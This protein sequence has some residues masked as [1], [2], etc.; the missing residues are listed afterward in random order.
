MNIIKTPFDFLTNN[1]SLN[2]IA[3][4]SDFK[5]RGS[6]NYLSCFKYVDIFG[7]PIEL[8]FHGGRRYRSY[9]S[10]LISTFIIGICLYL[11][12]LQLV[13]WKNID[14]STIIYSTENFSVTSLLNN[15]RSIE[16]I[17]NNDNYNIYFAVW[18]NLPDG[19]E[20]N[21]LDLAKYFK[22]QFKYSPTG[23]EID[24]FN[25]ESETCNTIAQNN[26]LGLVYD[27]SIKSDDVNEFQMCIKNPYK[28]GLMG[29]VTSQTVFS[30]SILFEINKCRNNSKIHKFSCASEEEIQQIIK[31]VTI[32]AS[33]PKTIFDLK[34]KTFPIKRIYKY[35]DYSLD[36][37]L[38]KRLRNEIDPT[39]LYKD[40][41]YLFDDY[42]LDSLNFNPNQPTI[43]I[44]TKDSDSNILFQYAITS[45]FQI[46]KLYVKNQ[47]LNEMLGSYGGLINLLYTI[48]NLIC[49][50]IN[51]YFL[52]KSL[53]K[54]AFQS[55]SQPKSK[56][57]FKVFGK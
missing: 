27:D 45:S 13:G 41:G 32:Q 34:N 10:A 46:E 53:L 47:K 33:I 38:I 44:N 8:Y 42:I 1:L 50:Y 55:D 57:C 51:S 49:Y 21:Y 20:L 16:Y 28:M 9:I 22:I 12:C 40:F 39:Y 4:K 15:N 6:K 18:A 30:P 54:L 24:A 2:Q 26:F 35:E 29:D 43:N 36:S 31:Y 17:L 56:K 37:N 23:Y 7:V 11:L 48:G 19:N 3:M 52:S 5:K 25:I 14:N